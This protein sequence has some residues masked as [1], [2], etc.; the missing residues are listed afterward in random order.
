[1]SSN[2]LQVRYQDEEAQRLNE[3]QTVNENKV[4]FKE[5]KK[6]NDNYDVKKGLPEE[7]LPERVLPKPPILSLL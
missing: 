6:R 7:I 2:S 1:M 3:M 5:L 4:I